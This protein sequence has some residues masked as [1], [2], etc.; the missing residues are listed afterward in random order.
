MLQGTVSPSTSVEPSLTGGV[1]QLS[2]GGNAPHI[3]P[4]GSDLDYGLLTAAISIYI[5]SI[6]CFRFIGTTITWIMADAED[7]PNGHAGS[8]AV[9]LNALVILGM[10]CLRVIARATALP[11]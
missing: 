5:L 1:S 9:V 10:C 6:A 3:T 4:F 8:A 7:P 11:R 2:D